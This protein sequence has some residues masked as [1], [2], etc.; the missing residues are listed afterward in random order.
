[1]D[2]DD[3][4]W[5][6]DVLLWVTGAAGPALLRDSALPTDARGFVGTRSTL[7]VEGFDDLLAVGDCATLEAYPDTPK[8]GVYAVR[9]GPVLARNLRALLQGEPL[10][11]YRPQSDF[12]TLLNLG[13]GT[14]LGTK[15]GISFEGRWV[16]RWK[17]WIDRRFMARFQLAS[18]EANE[19][20]A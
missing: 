9:Q 19:E 10:E 20:V 7:Q 1:V 8:A 2:Q 18:P 15:K 14:A 13:D 3:R 5:P 6:F 4:S 12:L 16:M 17:D 11:S